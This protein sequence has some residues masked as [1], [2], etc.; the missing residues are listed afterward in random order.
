MT[1]IHGLMAL[2]LGGALVA[3]TAG[4]SKFG[5]GGDGAGAAAGSGTGGLGTGGE[6]TGGD[7]FGGALNLGGAGGGGETFVA[8]VFGHSA[9]ELYKLDP[10]TK[11]V[12]SVGPFQG[13]SSVIDI[14]IDKDGDIFGTTFSG[15]YSI[16]KLTAGC[17]QISTGSYPNS[18]SFVPVGTVDASAEAL[19]G[20]NGGT[21]VRIDTV[22]GAVSTIGSIGGG[23]SSSGDIV[24]VIGGGTYLTVTGPGCGDCLIRVDP[25]TGS[26][27][28]NYGPIGYSQVF[29]LAFWGGAAFGF[30]NAGQLFQ[31]DFNGN[32]VSTQAIAIPSAPPGLSFWGAGSSTK[33]P[34]VPPS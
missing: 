5:S 28:Q 32:T 14:A 11:Q 1:R 7:L 21:Y 20:Y 9:G 6:G 18:L 10:I 24:S 30:T 19:V 27:Q 17:T 8:E 31:I 29:G 22:S 15:L 26:L 23:L 33:A 16:D 13:C 3:C 34:L 25:T 12:T 4:T 2:A